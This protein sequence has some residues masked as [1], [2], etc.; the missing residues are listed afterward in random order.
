MLRYPLCNWNGKIRRQP[1]ADQLNPGGAASGFPAA[2]NEGIS[3]FYRPWIKLKYLIQN[4][5]ADADFTFSSPLFDSAEF[6]NL[7]MDFN[8]GSGNQ[9]TAID[10]HA[11]A[12]YRPSSPSSVASATG[13]TMVFPNTNWPNNPDPYPTQINTTTG[14]ITSDRDGLLVD[15]WSYDVYV[16]DTGA[17]ISTCLFELVAVQGGVENI[18]ISH[19][20]TVDI[21]A[22]F[23]GFHN[24][25]I[26]DTG[27][28]LFMRFT[29]QTA[30][31]ATGTLEQF[32]GGS[33]NSSHLVWVLQGEALSSQDLLNKNRGKLKQWDFLK[34]IFTMFNLVTIQDKTNPTNLIIDTYDNTFLNNSDSETF[35]WTQKVDQSTIQIEPLK[36]KRDVLLKYKTDDKDYCAKVFKNA[37]SGYEY[38]SKRLDG[39]TAIPGESLT[40]LTGQEKI[41]L[42]VFSST[43]VK[44]IFYDIPEWIAPCIYGA[45]EDGS[46]FQSIENNPRIL[47]NVTGDVNYTLTSITFFVPPENGASANNT[48]TYQR[49][50]HTSTIPSVSA[51]TTGYNFENEYGLV[52]SVGAP[53]VDNLFNRFYQGYFSELYNPDTRIVKISALLSPADI[54]NFEFYDKIQ[55]KN[56]LYR[57]NKIDYKP[58]A[59]TKLELILIA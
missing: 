19:T 53:P 31:G 18:L 7:Y 34:D 33:G 27:D 21:A 20:L 49:F 42:K 4:I 14:V 24:G 9:P 10:T 12:R 11:I 6:S 1:T 40:N 56:R 30:G 54:A 46:E 36:L 2:S 8:W 44:P 22:N 52:G 43:V 25:I 23:Y 59:L 13:T 38:G 16:R 45:N 35:D 5:F 3:T 26:L 17:A 48:S 41:E 51:T 29:D 47:Y 37:C 32:Y 57:V 55:I 15:L 28:T 39:S 58:G 50:S